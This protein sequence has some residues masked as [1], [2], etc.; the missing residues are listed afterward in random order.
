MQDFKEILAI[1]QLKV[2]YWPCESAIHAP[3]LKCLS[4]F[5]TLHV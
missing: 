2:A 4:G 1:N 3:K 5:T